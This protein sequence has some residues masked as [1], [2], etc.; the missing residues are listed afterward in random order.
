MKVKL[1]KATELECEIGIS[2]L[3]FCCFF[4][5]YRAYQ[6]YV[7]S[8]NLAVI[9]LIIEFHEPLPVTYVLKNII[10]I[11]LFTLCA[12]VFNFYLIWEGG[13]A[14]KDHLL[15]MCVIH[16]IIIS[17]TRRAGRG[18][19]CFIHMHFSYSLRNRISA[20]KSAI[21][22]LRW[23]AA[24]RCSAIKGKYSWSLADEN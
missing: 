18:I 23:Y 20:I 10:K 3:G 24:R 2:L 16:K 9:P 4:F 17:M 1:H 6:L 8:R 7:T 12:S 11:Y 21:A 15:I 13:L 22:F 14:V 19:F 5:N